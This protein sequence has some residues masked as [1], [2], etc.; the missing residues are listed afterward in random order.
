MIRLSWSSLGRYNYTFL[1]PFFKKKLL[2]GFASLIDVHLS[3]IYGLIIA[4][5]DKHLEKKGLITRRKQF[6]N[7]LFTYFFNTHGNN[8]VPFS[9]SIN[10]GYQTVV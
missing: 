4:K 5:F 2:E 3:T 1:L 7:T 10:Y 9:N 8:Y 6:A